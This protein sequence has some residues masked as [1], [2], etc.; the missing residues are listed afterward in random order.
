MIERIPVAD[1]FQENCYFYVDPETRQGF[2]IDPG[3]EAARIYELIRE[4]RLDIQAILLT[5]GHFDHTGAV[6]ELHDTLGI[7]YYISVPGQQYLVDPRLNLSA[8]CGRHVVL[9][10]A[11]FFNEG[12][13]L[14]VPANPDFG[15]KVI[16]T[17]GHTP[18]SVTLYSPAEKAAFVGDA[19]F[20]GSPGTAQFPGGDE[21]LLMQSIVNKILKLPEDT[22][23][24]S[25]HSLP[26]TVAREKP[27][28]RGVIR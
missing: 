20:L 10:E 23:L 27:H 2:I 7:P 11:Q 21:P 22:T 28:Y 15:L 16:A 1:V 6:Q 25:G 3:A 17:P 4:N 24:Y 26:T 5:H 14:S 13:F 19:I 12:D 18:D 9:P 8:E